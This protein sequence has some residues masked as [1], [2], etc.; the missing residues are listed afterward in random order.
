[1]AHL[2]TSSCRL[3]SVVVVCAAA[4]VARARSKI[5]GGALTRQRHM[6]G[7]GEMKDQGNARNESQRNS[8]SFGEI[9]VH[10]NVEQCDDPNSFCLGQ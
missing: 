8:I 1:M 5:E 7:T 9:S 2:L 6:R 10:R 4:R 3:A